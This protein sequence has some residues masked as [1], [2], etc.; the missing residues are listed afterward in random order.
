MSAKVAPYSDMMQEVRWS[1]CPANIDATPLFMTNIIMSSPFSPRWN[2]ETTAAM[3][4]WLLAPKQEHR[5]VEESRSYPGSLSKSH[6][7]STNVCSI[8]IAPFVPSGSRRGSCLSLRGYNLDGDEFSV[9]SFIWT[10]TF[11]HSSTMCT[12]KILFWQEHCN[13]CNGWRLSCL[14]IK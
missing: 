2:H 3:T 8:D 6:S 13:Y 7:W 4:I 12:G 1:F 9:I 10:T 14:T 5:N 11:C